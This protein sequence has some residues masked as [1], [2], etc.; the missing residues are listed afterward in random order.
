MGSAAPIISTD[1][2][3]SLQLSKVFTSKNM[4]CLISLINVAEVIDAHINT[5][6][7]TGVKGQVS[8]LYKTV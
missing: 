3:F 7:Y 5:L 2:C 4:T 8:K 6:A 1:D